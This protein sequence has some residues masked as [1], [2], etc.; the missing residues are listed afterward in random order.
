VKIT[1]VGPWLL[2]RQAKAR[3]LRSWH[4]LMDGSSAICHLRDPL[5]NSQLCRQTLRCITR[6]GCQAMRRVA[7]YVTEKVSRPLPYRHHGPLAVGRDSPA[8]PERHD[9]VS[10]RLKPGKS[11]TRN[12][13]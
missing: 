7:S 8:R 12:Q 11:A 13:T 3:L 5:G 9:K 10:I 4:S 2:I 1:A 6:F